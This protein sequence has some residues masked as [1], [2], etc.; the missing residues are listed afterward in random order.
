[1][2]QKSHCTDFHIVNSQM[3]K[4]SMPVLLNSTQ[5]ICIF[6]CYMTI[7]WLTY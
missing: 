7:G 6:Y 3:N 5:Q 1:M 2:G 4:Y